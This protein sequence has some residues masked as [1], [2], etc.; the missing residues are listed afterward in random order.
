MK[1]PETATLGQADELLR[2]LQAELAAEGGVLYIDAS[3]LKTFD[4]STVALLLQA[5]RL[6]Q[7]AGRTVQLG[8]L[9]TKLAELARLYGV[10]AL[11]PVSA[12]TASAAA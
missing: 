2:Q 5:R 8:G 4:T 11:L 7:A 6:G 1:L 3:A 9:P 10:E 12:N